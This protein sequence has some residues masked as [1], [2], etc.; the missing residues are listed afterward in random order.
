WL[1]QTAEN[2]SLQLPKRQLQALLLSF[3]F[4]GSLL[5]EVDGF[6]FRRSEAGV[7]V[8]KYLTTQKNVQ[9]VA[10]EQ[11]WRAGGKIY[12]HKIPQVMDI[13]PE[14][15]G[16]PRYF[17]KI[18]DTPGLQIVA[19]KENDVKKYHYDI[20]LIK[21]GF[22]EFHVPQKGRDKYRLFKKL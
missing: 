9:S 4:M 21:K 5:F 15:I 8:A 16:D 14:T 20:V 22:E 18:I 7:D 3:V 1:K 10:F 2:L 12:L 13:S 11:I 17:M 19:L 6:R